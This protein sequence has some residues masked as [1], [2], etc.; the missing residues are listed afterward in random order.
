[1]EPARLDITIHQ[2]AT[3]RKEF[4]LPFDCTGHTILAQVWAERRRS[5]LFEFT[6]EWIDQELG[7]FY[8]VANYA[9]TTQ[10]KKD[11]IWDLMVIQPDEERYYWLEGIAKLDPGITE[12]IPPE[13]PPV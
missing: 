6:T 1:M 5:L 12:P 13:P 10:M 7:N 11:G 3:F 4:T 8:L 9:D 2:R